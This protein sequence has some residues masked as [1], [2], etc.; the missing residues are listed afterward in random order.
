MNRWI[1]IE[2]DARPRSEMRHDKEALTALSG[3]KTVDAPRLERG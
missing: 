3:S 1:L 2:V